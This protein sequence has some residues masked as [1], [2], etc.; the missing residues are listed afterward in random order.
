MTVTFS[1]PEG[2]VPVTVDSRRIERI[3]RNLLANAIDHS[4]GKPVEVDVVA[5]D[6][7][8]AIA[9]TDHGVGLKPGQEELVFNRF[10]R[11][12]PARKR[13][14]GGTGLGLAIAHED[15]QLHGG[16]LDAVGEPGR[17]SRFRLTLPREPKAPYKESPIPL[18]LPPVADPKHA[19][20]SPSKEVSV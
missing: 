11:A 1:Q 18:E 8:V 13:H 2:Q 17:G 19:A 12:D 3:L 14:S 20:Q 4:E 16:T 5:T 10:W 9:V 6:D 15:A 7:A